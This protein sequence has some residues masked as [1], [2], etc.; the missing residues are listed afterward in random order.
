MEISCSQCQTVNRVPQ[1]RV[2]DGAVCAQCKTPLLPETPVALTDASFDRVIGGTH[3]LPVVVDFWAPWCGPCRMMGPMFLEAAATLQ[4]EAL[5]A[6]LDTEANPGGAGRFGIRSIPTVVI[7]LDG[8]E[9]AR[10]SGV[11]PAAEIVRW[12]R[13]HL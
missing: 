10:F 12:V 11:R 2:H 1:E 4:G 5:L 3:G 13:E 8:R 9:L 7:F 6:K